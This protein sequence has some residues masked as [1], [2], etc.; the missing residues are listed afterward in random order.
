[1]KGSAILSRLFP[2][3]QKAEPEE[4]KP[5]RKAAMSAIPVRNPEVREEVLSDE[6]V[7]LTYTITVKPMFASL[8]KRLGGGLWVVDKKLELDELGTAVW[9]MVD[10]KRDVRALCKAFAGQYGFHLREAELSVTTFIREL[11]KRGIIGLK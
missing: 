11:G 6:Q 9:R 5:D 3:A 2:K 7:R 8:G 10:G 4:P 1:M